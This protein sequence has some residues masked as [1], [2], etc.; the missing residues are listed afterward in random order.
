MEVLCNSPLRFSASSAFNPF[1]VLKE[2]A[3]STRK[4]KNR[5]QS[6]Y[7]VETFHSSRDPANV[8]P[9]LKP[10]EVVLKRQEL[11]FQIRRRPEQRLVQAFAPDG[12][13]QSFNERMRE[14]NVGNG[15]DFRYVQ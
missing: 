14:R 4:A 2:P 7:K 1:P 13:D 10:V 3:R 6:A 9:D 5:K 11:Q 15:F 8:R 12:P